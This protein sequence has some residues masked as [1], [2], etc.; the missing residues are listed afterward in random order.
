MLSAAGRKANPPRDEYAQH[1]AVGEQRDITIN[2]ARGRYHSIHP[3]A[4][5]IR[6]FAARTSISEQ[7]PPRRQLV[8]L[9]WRQSLVVAVVPFCQ[10]G[11]HDCPVAES[12]QLAGVTRSPHWTAQHQI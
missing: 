6:G 10:L 2:G 3:R 11:R 4:Y 5:F 8:N 9:H 12:R 1:V 7:Q